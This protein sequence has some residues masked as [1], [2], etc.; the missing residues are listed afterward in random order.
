LILKTLFIYLGNSE[1]IFNR[2]VGSLAQRYWWHGI[3]ANIRDHIIS[4]HTCRSGQ[5]PHH[6]IYGPTKPP[7]LA[8]AAFTRPSKDST[9]K[10]LRG[11]RH[12]F[13]GLQTQSSRAQ[14]KPQLK[15][16]ASRGLRRP[17]LYICQL[18]R[19]LYILESGIIVSIIILS[20]KDFPKIL[21]SLNTRRFSVKLFAVG[22]PSGDTSSFILVSSK[23]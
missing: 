9:L 7:N 21:W 16:I 15:I 2:C 6:T 3:K 5:P 10:A 4:C 19:I 14:C 18:H 22:P 11:S 13:F 17:A 20:Q 1:S 8:T 23:C 12:L